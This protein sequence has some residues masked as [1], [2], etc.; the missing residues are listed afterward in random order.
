[1]TRRLVVCLRWRPDDGGASSEGFVSA[2]HGVI[3]RL[4]ALGGRLVLWHP[5]WLCV[6][7]AIEA[8]QDAI[9]FV[10]DHP[11]VGFSVGFAYGK[12]N[13]LLDGG[14]LLAACYG[15]AIDSAIQMARMARAREVLVEPALVKASGGELLVQGAKVA[16]MGD[17]RV[18]GFKLDLAHP[19][20]SLECE[21]VARLIP[22]PWLGPVPSLGLREAQLS[23]VR[24]PRGG[25]GSRWLSEHRHLHH[26]GGTVLSGFTYAQPLGVLRFALTS[27]QTLRGRPELTAQA[28]STWEALSSGQGCSPADGAALLVAWARARAEFAVLYLEDVE[29]FDTDSLDVVAAAIREG[30]L[31]A[32]V[33]IDVEA[34]LP[35]ALRKL[36]VHAEATVREPS[37]A[38][39]RSLLK[40]MTGDHL[41][42]TWAERLATRGMPSPL[43]VTQSLV[44]ALDS[45]S[46][47]WTESGVVPRVQRDDSPEPHSAMSLLRRRLHFLEL[48]D[49]LLLEA[50]A[51]LGGR[52]QDDQVVLLLKLAGRTAT[53]TDVAFGFLERLG[54]VVQEPQG[55][56]ALA[57]RTHRVAIVSSLSDKRFRALHQA[58]ATYYVE[59]AEPCGWVSAAVHAALAGNVGKALLLAK[60]AIPAIRAAGFELTALALE[61]YVEQ[62]N[63][64]VLAER[65]LVNDEA[66]MRSR[67]TLQEDQLLDASLSP[68]EG[69]ERTETMPAEAPRIPTP[70]PSSP[71]LGRDSRGGTSDVSAPDAKPEPA[72]DVATVAP[73]PPG[74]AEPTT[75]VESEAAQS[76]SE[77]AQSEPERVSETDVE[78]MSADDIELE[79]AS[80]EPE[81]DIQAA[82]VAE[83]AH[84]AGVGASPTLRV[85][86][87]PSNDSLMPERASLALQRGDP[88]TLDQLARQLRGEAH[89]V[90]ADRLDAMASLVRGHTGEAL[91][92]LRDAKARAGQLT[93][94]EQC[95]ASLALSVAI[96]AAG[97]PTD[98]LLEVLE[99]L[100]KARRAGDV[101]GER[102]C[103]K[104]LAQLAY[105][106]GHADVAQR[107]QALSISP[108]ER[109]D[110]PI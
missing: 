54:W 86:G 72:L 36:E 59:R 4:S 90:L 49:R 40:R 63:L 21:S 30:Q 39:A 27:D 2:A 79:P 25:G 46:F 92:R 67:V 65:G 107:W 108:S 68:Q 74:I 80:E 94:S 33:A 104:F 73:A 47:L 1:M 20:R 75:S 53:N 51:V 83:A 18:R 60:R 61:Q 15:P 56:V 87:V 12:L 110:A 11:H 102:A 69:A 13:E 50:L 103:A 29:A 82:R 24:A 98:A 7:F 106:A 66:A 93:L 81:G 28:T 58:A 31:A 76:E 43:G 45:A 42:D 35:E 52:A 62:G 16:T 101:R 89:N 44:E 57:S 97:R 22:P 78:A 19:Q 95:R 99:G 17:Q 38:E 64:D 9:D 6:D 14:P 70:R 84:T 8:L 48:T 100:A 37:P 91:R 41:D 109:P 26:E 23:V 5:E 10:V 88:V 105:K 71:A 55:W 85:A 3:E 34:A 77:A 32:V 96:A